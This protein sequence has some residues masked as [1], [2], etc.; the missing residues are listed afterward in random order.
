M[1]TFSVD[2]E[3]PVS[4]ESAPVIQLTPD[5]QRWW[6][7]AHWQPVATSYPPNALRKPDGSEWWDGQNWRRVPSGS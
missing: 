5:G 6:D 1:T 3:S 2:G 7:G 4:V